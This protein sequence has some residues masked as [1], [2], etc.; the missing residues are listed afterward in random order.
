MQ[1]SRALLFSLI[2]AAPNPLFGQDSSEG[3]QKVRLDPAP[4]AD[5]RSS[6]LSRAVAPIANGIEAPYYNP[7][8]IG[9]L[10][11]EGDGED[12]PA[13]SRLTVPFFAGS[14][15]HNSA[16]LQRQM[17]Q[18]QGL[19]NTTMTDEILQAQQGKRH[20]A[21]L[22]IVPNIQFYRMFLA[23]AYDQQ[24]AAVA[25][26]KAGEK[27]DIE[28]R[29]SSGLYGGFSLADDTEN[30]LFGLT[31][32]HASRKVTAGTF[33]FAELNAPADRRAAFKA[34]QQYYDGLPIHTGMIW[35]I[36]DEWR[37]TFSLVAR[38]LT[39]TRYRSRNENVEDI[40]VQEDLSLAFALS[41]EVIDWGYANFVVEAEQLTETESSLVKK[42]RVGFELSIGN[43]FGSEAAFSLQTGYSSA[44]LSFGLGVNASI[45]NIHIASYAED[46][47]IANHRVIERR[48]VANF[49]VNVAAF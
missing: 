15:H 9:G 23:Y 30:F 21:R 3:R 39:G 29:I 12:R 48:H 11:L 20:Y 14:L 26:D 35:R 24:L 25:Q 49:A 47:G 22:S 10:Y 36:A 32:G 7:A 16:R 17:S 27:I 46:V 8:G 6:G 31:V 33:S 18:G 34:H 2:F 19:D 5:A 44:G 4:W 1:R 37:P 43:R 45:L 13:V 38:D 28:M 41:P 42:L 40:R